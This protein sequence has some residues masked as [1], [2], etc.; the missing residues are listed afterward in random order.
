MAEAV[1][2]PALIVAEWGSDWVE[3]A[4]RLIARGHCVRLVVQARREPIASFASRARA[5][6]TNLESTG[7]PPA[8]AIYVGAG[9]VGREETGVRSTVVRTV[10]AAMARA[11]GGTVELVSSPADRHGIHAL[12]ITLRELLTH[13][14]VE[15][16]A[17]DGGTLPRAA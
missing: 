6:V 17:T 10:A 14:G 13:T 9:R 4:R 12:A 5:A 2:T 1:Q 3:A 15:V 8:H 11:G 7:S 16:R